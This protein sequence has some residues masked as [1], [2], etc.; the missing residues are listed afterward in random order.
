[1]KTSLPRTLP[2]F[3]ILTIAALVLG[4]FAFQQTDTTSAACNGCP[5]SYQAETHWSLSTKTA[6]AN[7]DVTITLNIPSPSLNFYGI[8]FN[9]P[10]SATISAGPPGGAGL[11]DIVGTLNSNPTS[12]GL[13]NGACSSSV[14]VPFKLMNATVDNTGG[15]TMS[16]TSDTD[17]GPVPALPAGTVSGRLTPY[18]MDVPPTS[19]N[20]TPASGTGIANDLPSGVDRY[21]SFLNT[22]FQNVAPLARYFGAT[23]VG[24]NAVTLNFLVFSPG[25][26]GVIPAP[27]P[28]NDMGLGNLGYSSVTVLNDPTAPAAPSGVTDFCTP[29]GT[30]SLLYGETKTNPCGGGDGS[31]Q[32]AGNDSKIDPAVYDPAPGSPTGRI[33]YANPTA[34]TRL[35]T[36]LHISQRDLDGDGFENGLDG[37]PYTNSSP[38]NPRVGGTTGDEDQDMIDNSCDTSNNP[39]DSNQD[40]DTHPNGSEWLN[41]GDNCPQVSNPL[42]EE[43][44]LNQPDNVSRPRGGSN[45]DSI[46]D[47]CDTA[48]SGAQCNNALDD[49]ADTLVNDGCPASGAAEVGCLNN[50]DDDNDGTLNDGCPSSSQVANGTYH[51]TFTVDAI[52]IGNTDADGDGWCST[53]TPAGGGF[54]VALPADPNDNDATKTPEAYAL[55]F[56]FPIAHSGAGS[57]PADREPAQVCNDGVDN[58]GDTQIDLLDSGCKPPSSLTLAPNDTDG[59]GWTDEEEIYLGTDALGRCEKKG[60]ALSTDW[61]GDVSGGGFSED[62]VNIQDLSVFT[63]TPK[64]LNTS[65]GNPDFDRR[66]DV[67]PGSTFGDWINVGDLSALTGRTAPMFGG[68]KMFNGPACT[69]H[70]TLND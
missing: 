48:E 49:D 7:A 57:S 51:A 64:R 70:P 59:D 3:I 10:P 42:N 56:P 38:W 26:L 32:A 61:P 4:F 46:G 62:K 12:L 66:Y 65:P 54:T 2:K 53:S 33:R 18:M 45:S 9:Y 21:P 41:A 15:N 36:T 8:N 55:L 37:C 52:C 28:L 50:A 29:L 20:G 24:G 58:D 11:G 63:G 1:M 19:G 30:V 25:A 43:D 67:L 60:P 17:S 23:V 69:A 40:G 14:P 31:C 34:G 5:P 35:Y 13:T 6:G 22:M 39:G 27:N 68:A 44:E 16:P 47:A